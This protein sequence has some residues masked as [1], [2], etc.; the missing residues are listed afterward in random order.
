MSVLQLSKRAAIEPSSM[1]I[2]VSVAARKYWRAYWAQ[3]NM[4]QMLGDNKQVN[5]Y[6]AGDFQGAQPIH[7]FWLKSG[8]PA[9]IRRSHNFYYVAAMR[10]PSKYDVI[11][12]QPRW[13]E[14]PG[15]ISQQRL[16]PEWVQ[17]G[18]KRR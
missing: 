4:P 8:E 14:A 3:H 11:V 6:I 10:G 17:K 2:G 18:P 12:I 15:E 5:E 1:G 16:K 13:H 7:R 9:E